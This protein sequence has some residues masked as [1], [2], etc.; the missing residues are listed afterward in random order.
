METTA[1]QTGH[2]PVF[3]ALSSLAISRCPLGQCTVI[4]MSFLFPGVANNDIPQ[5]VLA[6]AFGLNEVESEKL[7]VK[8]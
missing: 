4:D 2:R 8:S 3:P 5:P 6:T 7:K 1:R